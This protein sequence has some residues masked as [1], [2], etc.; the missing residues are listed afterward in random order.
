MTI[1]VRQHRRGSA[2]GSVLALVSAASFGLSG[3]LARG[4][5]D[6]G[7]SA[8]A[9]VTVRIV[10]RRARAAAVP[11]CLALRGR[12]ALL[13]GN[14]SLVVLYGVVAVAGAQFCYFSAVAAHAG[15]AGAA[16]RVHRAGRRRRLAVAAARPAPR[17]AD[18]RRRRG[19]A[20]S[21]WCWCST[22]SPAPTSAWSG[23]LWA[24][25]A[26]VG[27]RRTSCSRPTR[28]TACR[29]SCWPPAGWSSARW[30]WSSLGLVGLLPM[31]A[32]T[33]AV[34]YAGTTVAW[35]V[36]VLVL[37][38]VTAALSYVT[39]IAA[40]RRLGSRLAS[41]VALSEVVAG[42]A[43]RLAAARRAAPARPAARRPADPGRRGGGQARRDRVIASSR[44]HVR[45]ARLG[46]QEHA[47]RRGGVSGRPGG[48]RR[49]RG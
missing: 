48:G 24:L 42:A 39:G 25:G 31:S 34:E 5:L 15:R 18:A 46:A 4:L 29:R 38:V 36:P 30:P 10:H 43:V 37:G 14:A 12:W 16:D 27:A 2:A 45:A 47:P 22:C 19:R 26:M 32:T 1:P 40:G 9:A 7:W 35:W 33:D 6:A 3:S 8:G 13:R 49:P 20:R 21:G 44:R 17:P 28:T 11:A 23:V 41:F